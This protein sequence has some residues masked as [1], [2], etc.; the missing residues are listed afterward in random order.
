MYHAAMARSIPKDRFHDLIEAASAV[1]LQQG[2]RRTQM[3]DVAERMGVAKGTVYLYV[4]SKEALFD[5]VMRHA[6]SDERIELPPTLPVPTPAPGATL[7]MVRKRVARSAA[8][9]ALAA[10]LERRRVT[11]AG[12]E[13]AGIVR[14]LYALLARHRVAIKLLDRC[15]ADHPELAAVWYGTGREGA[16]ALL[17][18]YLAD[19][20]RRGQLVAAPD[21][22]VTARIILETVVFWAVHR[23]WDPAPQTVDERVAEETVVAFVTR[24][25]IKE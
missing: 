23:H 15:S 21:V 10:A 7:E 16:L 17:Q 9:P 11:D 25:L 8:L 24:A 5:A 6:D 19:R 1:F 12:R 18:R 20:V 4:E 14:E 22:A 2:Y 13:V 3:A